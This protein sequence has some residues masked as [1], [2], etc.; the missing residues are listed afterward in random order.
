MR[1]R[2]TQAMESCAQ[3]LERLSA[4]EYPHREVTP[5]ESLAISLKRIE[6]ALDG[7]GR[8]LEAIARAKT[9]EMSHFTAEQ[10]GQSGA[11]EQHRRV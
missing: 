10:K 11:R 6:V 7:I 5:F 8:S 2:K 4:T 1:D 9:G 3:S